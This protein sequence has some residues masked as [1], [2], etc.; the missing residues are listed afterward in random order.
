[1]IGSRSGVSDAASVAPR[2]GDFIH[3]HRDEIVAAWETAVR[4]LPTARDLD[5][6]ALID[7]IPDLLDHIADMANEVEEGGTA[8]LPRDLAQVHA[9]E[10]LGEGFDLTEVVFE[11]SV[12][13]D[14]ITRLWEERFASHNELLEFRVLNRA[15]DRSVSASIDRYT[16]AR[17]RTLQAVD[18]IANAALESRSLDD[19]LGRLLGVLVETT[20]AVDTA[21]I[22]LRDGDVLHV[23]ASFGL[24]EEVAQ[25]VTQRVGE[26]FAGTIAATQKPLELR[27]AATDPLV[28]REAL[29]KA[30][31]RALYGVPLADGGDVIAVAHMG[32]LTAHEFSMQDKRL[33]AAMA[34][35][36]TAAIFQ[37]ILRDAAEQAS[38][39]LRDREAQFRTLADNIPQLAWMA[40]RT[41]AVYWYNKRWYDFTGLGADE[42]MD[43]RTRV[44]HPDHAERVSESWQRA[45]ASGEAWAETFPLR[46]R[47]GRYR[48]FLSRAVPVV[49][50]SG[51]IARWFGTNTDVTDQRLVDEA[52]KVL[53]SSLNYHETLE[54]ISRLAVPDLCDWCVVDLVE[55]GTIERVAVAHADPAKK[56]LA[57]AWAEKYPPD[58]SESTGVGKVIATGEPLFA[59][60]VS[61]DA[62]AAAAR[63]ADH[64]KALRELGLSSIII[65]PMFARGRTLGAITLVM[66]ESG[67]RYHA[68]DLTVA[69]ELGRRAGIAVDNASLYRESQQALRS[70]EEVLA[71]VSHDLRT[72]LGTIDISA[73]NLLH[74]HG[75]IPRSRKLLE[76]IRR[77]TDRMEHLI[78]DLLDVA[79]IE[80]K[81]LSLNRTTQDPVELLRVVVET[82]EALASERSIKLI[83]DCEDMRGVRLWCDRDRIEQVF[84]NLLGNAKKYCRPGDVIFVRGA[85][86]GREA[87]FS[88]SDTGPGLAPAELPHLFQPYWAAKRHE[89][90]K[91]T[92]LGLY[93]C[94]GIVEAHG[95]KIGVEST[96]GEGATFY[97]TLPL[98]QPSP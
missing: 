80:A 52:T 57:R 4:T 56:E 64:L 68:S 6:P 7:H 11:F 65:A 93:I 48:W 46:G 96:Y 36:A 49:D 62:L 72:P 15:I 85:V 89:A 16:R 13:R 27:H 88:V 43:V 19:F 90:K 32:S 86:V 28:V 76:L 23:R 2:L 35:R 30:G 40:D 58:W 67:R 10:R 82:H 53:H 45:L 55:D 71:I 66:A 38:A 5:R 22:L 14:C 60:E 73:T 74:E 47:D 84:A 31:I 42:S 81:G 51:T 75:A 77:S 37:H 29:R 33:F 8:A 20:A 78:N 95:G 26:G 3:E 1:M 91:G 79:T 63:D 21:T 12:L 83:L 17:D 9:L 61:D 34:N 92:G 50:A 41:G 87:H 25:K 44:H 98:A 70:R 24:E 94:K 54:Q 69:Q 18:R 39:Q 59:R 97:F